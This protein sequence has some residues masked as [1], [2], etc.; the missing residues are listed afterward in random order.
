MVTYIDWLKYNEMSDNLDEYFN[1]KV[2][3]FDIIHHECR[4]DSLKKCYQEHKPVTKS[5]FNEY[6][7]DEKTRI[8]F[9]CN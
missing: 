7:E 9:F 3:I 4:G 5:D 1:K 8:V 2:I 6:P